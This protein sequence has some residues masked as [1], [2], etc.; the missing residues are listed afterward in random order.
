M[1]T[2]TVTATMNLADLHH[3]QQRDRNNV[4]RETV[5]LAFAESE[6]AAYCLLA[7]HEKRGL[8]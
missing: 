8:S 6:R 4:R 2:A 7:I 5:A 3:D 1:K